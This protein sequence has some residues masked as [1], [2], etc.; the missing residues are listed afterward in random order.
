MNTYEILRDAIINK[1]QIVAE[2]KG[3]TREMCPHALG[4]KNGKQQCL[5]YQFG[6]GSSQGP[7]RPGSDQNW[8]CIPV[9][10]L[11]DV[12]VREGEFFTSGNHSKAQTCIDR[13]D[14]EVSY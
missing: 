9:D 13:I 3:Y 6:G 1:K 8:R 10:G 7:V 11:E 14:V 12:E 5:F 2:Y 4:T